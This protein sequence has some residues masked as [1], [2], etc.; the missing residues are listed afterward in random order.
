MIYCLGGIASILSTLF[1][2]TPPVLAQTPFARPGDL[3]GLEESTQAAVIDSIV[4]VLDTAYVM[5]EEGKLMIEHLRGQWAEGSW[6]DLTDPVEF[7]RQLDAELHGVYNDRHLGLAALHPADPD[8]GEQGGSPFDGP[9]FRDRLRRGNYG[10]RKAEVLPGNI[11]YLELNQFADTDLAGETGVA[12]M[13][14]LANCDALIIDLRNN[15]GGSASMIQ[16]LTGYLLDEQTHL[17]NWYERDLDQTTQSWSQAY[18]PG[19]R[20]TDTQLYVLTSNRTGSAAEEFTFDLKNLGRATIVGDTT[21]GA[22]NTVAGMEF[23]FEG[24][25]LGMRFSYGAATDPR[26]GEGWEGTGVIPDL[27]VPADDALTVAQVEILETLLEEET[28]PSARRGVEWA[29]RGLRARLHPVTLTGEE[30]EEFTGTYGPRRIYLQDGVLHYQREGRAS[31]PLRPMGDDVFGVGD[32][33]YFRLRFVRD[34]QGRV[35]R[36]L[37]LYDSGREDENLRTG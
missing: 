37:G 19:K 22:G 20:L 13:N 34:G 16:L 33:E 32:L 28:D 3:P 10:F 29:L 8:G 2:A 36:V 26:T 4:A 6:R 15:G 14:F 21:G 5:V 7:I 12:A 31:Y 17:I 9:A 23:A 11:G 25:R 30:L 24:F 27:A 35:D 18:V 1:V